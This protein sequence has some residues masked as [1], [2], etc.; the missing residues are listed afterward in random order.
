MAAIVAYMAHDPVSNT[1]QALE[2]YDKETLA[3]LEG[4]GIIFVAVDGD[5]T[6]KVV[7]A[8]EVSEPEPQVNGVTLVTPIYVDARTEAIVAVFDALTAIVDPESSV[9]TA[10]ETGETAVATDPMQAF[11]DALASLKALKAQE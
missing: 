7:K 10:D 2:A 4:D 8:S 6:R 3:R 1:E 9:A 5:G 11:R